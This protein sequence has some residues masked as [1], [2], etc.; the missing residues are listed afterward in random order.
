M[1][2]G[3]LKWH[4][5]KPSIRMDDPL[6]SHMASM[7]IFSLVE[8]LESLLKD[9]VDR[10]R[11]KS[12]ENLQI[13]VFVMAKKDPRYR[14][15]ELIV[16]QKRHKTRLFGESRYDVGQTGNVPPGTVVDKVIVHS[17]HFDFYLCS[18][19]GGLGTSKPTHYNVLL[20]E[21]FFSSDQLQKLKYDMCYAFARCT[22]PVSL[23]PPIYYADLV[24]YRG[25][26]FQDAAMESQSCSPTSSS[27]A[28]S[29]TSLSTA[30]CEKRLHSLHPEL[31]N[32]MFFV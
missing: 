11:S 25:H 1:F 31:E 14:F 16:A 2:I 23:V 20:D 19:Y 4:C 27:H 30:W 9:V 13:I 24:A 21:N 5:G 22:M 32:I 12:K 15:L 7:R 29:S 6:V 3:N 18:H 10:A 26:L 28:I 8:S 17:F